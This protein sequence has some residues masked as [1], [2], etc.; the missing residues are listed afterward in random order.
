MSCPVNLERIE[1]EY[2]V[3]GGGFGKREPQ[4]IHKGASPVDHPPVIFK[5]VFTCLLKRQIRSQIRMS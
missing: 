4:L 2:S 3:K 1:R 5:K